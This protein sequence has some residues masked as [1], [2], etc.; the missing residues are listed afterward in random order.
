M[1]TGRCMGWVSQFGMY[2]FLLLSQLMA[3]LLVSNI[4][5]W[6]FCAMIR[7]SLQF[8]TCA[9][10]VRPSISCASDIL[11]AFLCRLQSK[12]ERTVQ[13]DFVRHAACQRVI[14]SLSC[15]PLFWLNSIASSSNHLY[16]ATL[17]QFLSKPWYLNFS[18]I[19]IEVADS[20]NS[21][22]AILLNLIYWNRELYGLVISRTRSH[23]Q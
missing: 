1:V 5:R 17:E 22:Q 6:P 19:I 16:Q 15:V 3:Y 20:A 9:R 8:V 14:L 13:V 12:S 2:T 4:M 7:I 10:A 18:I 21:C 23:F 11:H